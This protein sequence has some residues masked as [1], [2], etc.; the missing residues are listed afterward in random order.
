MAERCLEQSQETVIANLQLVKSIPRHIRKDDTIFEKREKDASILAKPFAEHKNII[1]VDTKESLDQFKSVLTL[2]E[3]KWVGV[4]IEHTKAQ[5]YHGLICLI[6]VCWPI[7]I[8]GKTCY[9]TF[10]IDTLA[11]SKQQIRDTLGKF[12]FEHP[13]VCKVMHG[14]VSSDIWWLAKDF[15]IRTNT[16]F[17][18]QEFAKYLE[19]KKTALALSALW[20]KYCEGLYDVQIFANKEKYQ[21]SDWAQRPLPQ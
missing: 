1:F 8:K 19:G 6:Q 15:G 11:F 10:L 4:D 17:D 2:S 7:K 18:T 13:L 16:V 12:L 20:A 21:K 5:A 3:P 14:C 9:Q